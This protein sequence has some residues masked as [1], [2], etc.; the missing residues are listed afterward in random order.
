ML[1]LNIKLSGKN[2]VTYARRQPDYSSNL[3]PPKTFAIWLFLGGVLG[4]LYKKT[5][6]R[7]PKTPRKKSYS[8]CFR[9]TQI[10]RV[11]WRSSICRGYAVMLAWQSLTKHWTTSL[12][13]RYV[14]ALCSP[15]VH[16]NCVQNLLCFIQTESLTIALEQVRVC[17]AI[18]SK[19]HL[20]L[21]S[22]L[23]W[24]RSTLADHE[25]WR[26]GPAAFLVVRFTP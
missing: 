18:E 16:D 3:C 11:I 2:T 1:T 12:Q 25:L 4:L 19:F 24:W 20:F 26:Q 8:K 17:W 9:W 21:H 14:H 13:M 5:T 23:H 10:G 6:G 15:W 7:R 22:V